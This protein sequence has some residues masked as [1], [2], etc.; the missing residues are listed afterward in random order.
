MHDTLCRKDMFRIWNSL[1][2]AVASL[3]LQGKG[4]RFPGLLDLSFDVRGEPMYAIEKDQNCILK[5]F[6]SG[7]NTHWEQAH[8]FLTNHEA[9][10][11]AT[12]P[13]EAVAQS[14]NK[15]RAKRHKKGDRL[16][17][18]DEHGHIKVFDRRVVKLVV[19]N[20]PEAASRISGEGGGRG[21]AAARDARDSPRRRGTP[22]L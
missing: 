10:V 21:D 14:L 5:H 16:A 3:M 12:L 19:Y 22:R 17:R 11:L 2:T 15:R 20:V 6:G 18:S 1:G 13:L 9:P 8:G 4:V 7:Y